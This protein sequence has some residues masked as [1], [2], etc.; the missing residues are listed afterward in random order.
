MKIQNH[1]M[2]TGQP[3]YYGLFIVTKYDDVR[4]KT[5]AKIFFHRGKNV[6]CLIWILYCLAVLRN[7]VAISKCDTF[8]II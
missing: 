2:H 4:C 6:S 3:V 5:P 8:F 1:P 7:K